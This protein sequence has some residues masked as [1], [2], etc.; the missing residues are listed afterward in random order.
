MRNAQNGMS[1]FI[2]I[3]RNNMS[4]VRKIM[5]LI[6]RVQSIIVISRRVKEFFRFSNFLGFRQAEMG[7]RCCFVRTG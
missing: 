2:S 7:E 5:S 4:L 3:V 6:V 1:N